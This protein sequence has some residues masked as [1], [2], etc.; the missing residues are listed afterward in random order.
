MPGRGADSTDSDGFRLETRAPGGED[1]NDRESLRSLGEGCCDSTASSDGFRLPPPPLSRIGRVEEAARTRP[2]D[3]LRDTEDPPAVSEEEARR[4]NPMPSSD[5]S[6]L[7]ASGVPLDHSIMRDEAG[8]WY[9][10]APLMSARNTSVD[11]SRSP[12]SSRTWPSCARSPPLLLLL[13]LPPSS[14]ALSAASITMFKGP[15]GLNEASWRGRRPLLACGGGGC[16][17]CCCRKLRWEWNGTKC[18]DVSCAETTDDDRRCASLAA[19]APDL[20]ATLLLRDDDRLFFFCFFG[21]CFCDRW[22]ELAVDRGAPVLSTA[23]PA[24]G[25]AE[26]REVKSSSD[27]ESLMHVSSSLSFF[28][29]FLL[30]DDAARCFFAVFRFV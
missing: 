26:D 11:A 8:R 7:K 13:A 17:G 21:F 1:R 27:L 20:S 12:R 9:V 28:A 29:P 22:P 18:G 6:T 19:A 15:S 16:C 24:S 3:S 30:R 25:F 5:A 2:P 14:L 4:G 23:T 10:T